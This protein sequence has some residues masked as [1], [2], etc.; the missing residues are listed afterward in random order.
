MTKDHQQKN[1]YQ[2]VKKREQKLVEFRYMTQVEQSIE[3]KLLD[4]QLN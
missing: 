1:M 3:N 2:E 4:R